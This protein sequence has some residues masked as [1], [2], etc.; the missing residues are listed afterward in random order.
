MLR[1]L[2]MFGACLGGALCANTGIK[3]LDA[4]G[5]APEWADKLMLFGQLVGDWEGD[6][7]QT[8][9]DGSKTKSQCEWHFGWI[10]G[11]KA[12]QD[13]WMEHLLDPKPSQKAGF[14][15]TVRLYDPRTGEWHVA[16]ASAREGNF[17]MF[18]ARQIGDEIVMEAKDSQGRPFRWIF[19]EITPQSFHWRS[20]GSPDGGKTWIVGQEMSLRR[21]GGVV[22]AGRDAESD[23]R[24]IE[25]LERE[26]LNAESGRAT[27]ERILA[28]DFVH[29]VPAGLFLTKQQHIDWS[30]RHPQPSGR[31]AEFEQL[32]VR[33]YGDTA[34]ATGIV[35]NTDL[36]GGDARRSIFT[37]VFAYR[38]GRW[39][40]VNAQEN[41]VVGMPQEH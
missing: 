34:I 12:I 16:F 39:Q 32:N 20:E 36:S 4:A 27:L 11:G 38:G 13:V 2:L 31:K 26:W 35:N 21:V 17:P 8:N 37:D 10:L 3:G 29:P 7:V 25:E 40:A 18:T 23:R 6:V 9:Q 33:L 24:A 41:G 5:P 1:Q 22:A 14:G 28:D 30:V 19:S 15:T